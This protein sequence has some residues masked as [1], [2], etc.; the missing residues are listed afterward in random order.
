MAGVIV[1]GGGHAAGQLAAGLRQQ[2]YADAI[3]IFADEAHPPYQRPPLS[4][5]YLSGEWGMDRLLLRPLNF[6][7]Q[8]SVRLHNG[9]S[10]SAIDRAA[11]TITTAAG[12]R[13]SYD[14]LVLATGSRARHLAIPGA[15]L[16]NVF[17]LRTAAD[18]D[19]IRAAMQAARRLV[20]VG[21][22]YIGL[23]VAA[24]A[25][26]AGLQV[27]VLEMESRILQ[28]V[29]TQGMSDFY[30]RVHTGHGVDI[31][32]STRVEELRGGPDVQHI[33]CADDITLAADLVVI[34]IGV[35]PNVE[36]AAA[37]GL[38]VD[39][40]VVVDSSCRTGDPHV[41][42]IGDCARGF[43]EVLGRSVRL[44]S[45]PNAMEQARVA[46]ATICGKASR[47]DTM[48]WFWSDQYDLKLQMVGFA[49]DGTESVLRGDPDS[50]SFMTFY[51]ADGRVVAADAVNQARDFLVTRQLCERRTAV[52][53]ARLADLSADLKL[54][55]S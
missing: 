45:V 53:T 4:K 3:A 21:G 54:L 6:Y 29:T 1:V 55:L 36:L 28:R 43:N 39:N 49:S 17:Y 14:H 23:E 22:G 32:V 40:G 27:T 34:G 19:A 37:A 7:S 47:Y 51:L 5:Q 15:D 13:H 25:R 52:T 20:I 16:G 38:N 26:K 31:R 9:V 18:V 46:A 35:L 24:V 8:K 33:A 50:N 11:Q 12:E 44:E 2:G 42:A 10:V 41:Y 48:P 30:H